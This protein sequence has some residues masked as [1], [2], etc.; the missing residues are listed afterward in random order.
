MR[1]LNNWIKT[2]LIEHAISTYHCDTLQAP[3]KVIDFGCG[4]GGDLDKWVRNKSAELHA[5]VGVD[6]ARQSLEDFAGRVAAMGARNPEAAA[7]VSYFERCEKSGHRKANIAVAAITT[8][9][10]TFEYHNM[11]LLDVNV[12]CGY[13]RGNY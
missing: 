13:C 10:G 7:K 12:I 6:I 2:A 1:N 11:L 3:L 5:Y 4:K 8:V 9:V